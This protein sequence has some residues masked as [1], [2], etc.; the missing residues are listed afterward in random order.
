VDLVKIDFFWG[1]ITKLL[2]ETMYALI[3]IAI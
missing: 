1:N 2:Q 3:K